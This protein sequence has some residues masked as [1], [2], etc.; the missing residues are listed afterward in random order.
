MNENVSVLH[1]KIAR[2]K[3]DRTGHS[4]QFSE[5]C[6]WVCA[7][8]PEAVN[9]FVLLTARVQLYL[10]FD[11]HAL[12]EADELIKNKSKTFFL[13]V[14][15]WTESVQFCLKMYFRKKKTAPKE[16]KEEPKG[17]RFVYLFGLSRSEKKTLR[18]L[19]HQFKWTCAVILGSVTW[20]L[21]S[22]PPQEKLNAKQKA[23]REPL[24]RM[25]DLNIPVVSKIKCFYL[26]EV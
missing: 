17:K 6:D 18:D 11:G 15:F 26:W 21:T 1:W 25:Y 20:Y 9:G 3:Q 10:G 24:M 12:L 2:W 23:S 16:R 13:G 19:S 4:A 7:Q 22:Y 14:V 8:F 5:G